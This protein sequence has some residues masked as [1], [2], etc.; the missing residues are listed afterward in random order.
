MRRPALTR[1]AP[2]EMIYMCLAC[3]LLNAIGSDP[4]VR[5]QRPIRGPL[6]GDI[7]PDGKRLTLSLIPFSRGCDGARYEYREA[8]SRP[9]LPPTDLCKRWHP[10]H[11]AADHNNLQVFALVWRRLL[12]LNRTPLRLGL[13]FWFLRG[14]YQLHFLEQSACD[15]LGTQTI[16]AGPRAL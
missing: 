2:E 8:G 10:N 7:A 16:I 1:V 9:G 14:V 11:V 3:N 12:P 5:P 13:L 4:L 15:R 6:P